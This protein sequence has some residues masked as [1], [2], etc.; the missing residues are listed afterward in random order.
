[1]EKK[2][3]VHAQGRQEGPLSLDEMRTRI[4]SGQASAQDHAWREG[5][6]DW[7]RVEDIVELKQTPS[8]PSP[9]SVAATPTRPRSAPP[10]EELSAIIN[11]RPDSLASEHTDIKR[12]K[13]AHQEAAKVEKIAQQAERRVD[14]ESGAKH[15]SHRGLAYLFVALLIVGS[16]VGV[17]YNQG[18]FDPW[19]KSMPRIDEL[20][21]EENSELAAA[22]TVDLHSVGPSVAFTL[23][24]QNPSAPV[25]YVGTNLPDGSTLDLRIHGIGP[26]LL[27]EIEFELY[28]PMNVSQKMAKS[29]PIRMKDGSAIPAGQYLISITDGSEQPESTQRALARMQPLQGLLPPAVPTGRKLLLKKV[30]TLLG[31]AREDTYASLLRDY[32]AK[33]RDQAAAESREINDW[34]GV[35]GKGFE[36]T[37]DSFQKLMPLAQA[38][39]RRRQWNAFHEEW[40]KELAPYLDKFEAY[41]PGAAQGKLFYGAYYRMVYAS[42]QALNRVHDLQTTFMTT[43]VDPATYDKEIA[44]ANKQAEERLTAL[45]SKMADVERGWSKTGYPPREGL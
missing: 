22:T 34:L 5:M 14:A 26:T 4:S 39:Q 20:T 38:D 36:T 37:E 45:K 12:L 13:V 9:P 7:K 31:G 17:A 44:E 15:S 30:F 33:L 10:I 1:M 28:I 25:V 32:H 23:S 42:W 3:F 27:N 18:Y 6:D 41:K 16:G 21:S 8:T 24:Q 40:L 19:I 43:I 35:L 29:P 11:M 2:W